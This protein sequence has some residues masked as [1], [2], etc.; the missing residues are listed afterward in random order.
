MQMIKTQPIVPRPPP[1]TNILSLT[2]ANP[3]YPLDAGTVPIEKSC[4]PSHDGNFLVS[5]TMLMDKRKITA[6]VHAALHLGFDI[7]I[8][9]SQLHQNILHF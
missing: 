2:A 6:K 7:M 3:K 4:G 9:K 1:K 5:H 8:I